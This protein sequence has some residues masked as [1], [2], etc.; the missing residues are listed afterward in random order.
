M[1]VLERMKDLWSY[2]SLCFASDYTSQ[3][4]QSYWNWVAYGAFALAG[5]IILLVGWSVSR[6]YMAFWRGRSHFLSSLWR[7]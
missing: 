2:V 3:V 4:C 1:S 6:D 7:D 5:L